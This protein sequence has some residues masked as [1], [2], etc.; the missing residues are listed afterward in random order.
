MDMGLGRLRESVMDR[1]AWHA[2]VHGVPKIQTRLRGWTELN[3]MWETWVWS[4]GWEDP[5]RM[6][7]LPIPVFLP[8]LY[9][10]WGPKQSDMTEQLSL[11]RAGD[12]SVLLLCVSLVIQMVKNWAAMHE[13]WVRFFSWEDPLKDTWQPTP[14]FLPGEFPWSEKPGRLQSMGSQRVWHDWM[15][16]HTDTFINMHI[17]KWKK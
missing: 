1:E 8:G 16:K 15:T 17:D 5:W 12:H 2:A 10:P 9:S 6:E 13:T 11:H 7:R 14:V 4:L 3:W